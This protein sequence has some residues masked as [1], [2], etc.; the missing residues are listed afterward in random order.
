MRS[1]YTNY[2][3]YSNGVPNTNLAMLVLHITTSFLHAI[4]L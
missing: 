4:V 2:Y 1:M 3:Y